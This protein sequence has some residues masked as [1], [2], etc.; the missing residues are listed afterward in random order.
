MHFVFVTRRGTRCPRGRE[1]ACR[2]A[3][4][5]CPARSPA[6][7]PGAQR[8]AQGPRGQRA[9]AGSASRLTAPWQGTTAHASPGG[10]RRQTPPPRRAPRGHLGTRLPGT[11]PTLPPASGRGNATSPRTT[12]PAPNQPPK[13]LHR[14]QMRWRNHGQSPDNRQGPPGSAETQRPAGE[15]RQCGL[16]AVATVRDGRPDG[17]NN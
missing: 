2:T 14:R 13:G 9:R 15:P 4:T 6:S 11:L 3:H 16:S 10:A 1:I 5:G 17:T 12:A 8:T 7:H